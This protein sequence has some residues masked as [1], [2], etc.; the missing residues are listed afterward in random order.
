MMKREGRTVAFM[1]RESA[2]VS[3][4][5]P[6]VWFEVSPVSIVADPSAWF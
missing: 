4:P 2:C 5:G 3:L 1:G 6:G